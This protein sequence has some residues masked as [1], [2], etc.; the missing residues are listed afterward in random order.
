M[1]AI[2]FKVKPHATRDGE[3]MVEVWRDDLFIAGIYPGNPVNAGEDAHCVSIVSKYLLDA[4]LDQTVP[5]HPK[6]VAH[7]SNEDRS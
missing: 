5:T 3:Q 2:T 1:M 4:T 7:F 6:L